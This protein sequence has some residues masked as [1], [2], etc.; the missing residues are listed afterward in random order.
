VPVIG[1]RSGDTK[2]Q[3]LTGVNYFC[4]LATTILAGAG[5]SLLRSFLLLQ[6]VTTGDRPAYFFVRRREGADFLLPAT[7]SWA[8]AVR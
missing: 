5:S 8:A 1:E 4:R 7:W 6:K 2:R 3:R